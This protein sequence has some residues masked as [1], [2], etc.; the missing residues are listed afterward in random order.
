MKKIVV[1]TEKT[2]IRAHV[3]RVPDEWTDGNVQNM[4][5][6][7]LDV[8]NWLIGFEEG[9]YVERPLEGA[10]GVVGETCKE[11]DRT[12]GLMG[13]NTWSWLEEGE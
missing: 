4:L 12:F 8:S 3:I 2:T 9:V 1:Y 6:G 13:W 11:T 5:W 10:K 7:E